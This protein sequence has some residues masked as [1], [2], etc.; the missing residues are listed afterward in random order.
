MWL[1]V[2]KMREHFFPFGPQIVMR[3]MVA[4]HWIAVL[5]T[6]VASHADFDV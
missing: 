6:A 1:L 3:L 2:A 5:M 4:I